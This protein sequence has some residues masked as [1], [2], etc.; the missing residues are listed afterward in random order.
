MSKNL[1]PEIYLD[2]VLAQIKYAL[3]Y[4]IPYSLVRFGHAEMRVAGYGFWNDN[5]SFV[6]LYKYTGI[7]ELSDEITLKLINAF[8][9]ASIVGVRDHTEYNNSVIEMILEHYN[10]KF[11]VNCSAWMNFLLAKSSDFYDVLRPLKIIVVGRRAAESVKKF[12]ELGIKVVATME[13]EGFGDIPKT[14]KAI[15]NVKDFDLALIAASVP[16]TI[17]CPDI[18]EMTGKVVIDYG[19]ALDWFVDGEN[20][21]DE[22]LVENFNKK[23]AEEGKA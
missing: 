1:G 12:N 13:H 5:N 7:T 19:H 8:K 14:M 3:K 23:I 15:S 6:D 22:K 18:A 9:K 21:D 16:A 17:M 2:Q 4:K 20:Y 11:P 10:L